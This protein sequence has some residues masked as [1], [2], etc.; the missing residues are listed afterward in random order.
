MMLGLGETMEEVV[1]AMRDLLGAGV[2]ALTLGQYLRP[3]KV[4]IEV[5]EYVS[6]ED[7][8]KLREEALR[9]GFDHVAAGPLVRSSYRAFEFMDS[10][11]E[12]V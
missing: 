10:R 7:F 6:P 11:N 1:E 3:G 9:L 4:N 2:D 5:K 8:N 12:G